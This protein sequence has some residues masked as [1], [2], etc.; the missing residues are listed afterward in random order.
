MLHNQYKRL[1]LGEEV[2][3]SATRI[4]SAMTAYVNNCMK[5]FD[6]NNDFPV[7]EIFPTFVTPVKNSDVQSIDNLE[8]AE[9][10][11]IEQLKN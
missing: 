1:K 9:A 10:F 2:S 5:N 4:F 7:F 11:A 8:S 6:R 3:K